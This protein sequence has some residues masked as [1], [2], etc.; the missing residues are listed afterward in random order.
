MYRLYRFALSGNS[1]KVRLML[2]LLGV[3]HELAA[4]GAVTGQLLQ[5]LQARLSDLS[6]LRRVRAL[7]GH[8]GMAGMPGG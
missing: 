7:P 1:H 8:V 3:E 6:W 2:W 4:A 5:V